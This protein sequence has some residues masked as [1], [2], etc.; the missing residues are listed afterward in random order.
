MISSSEAG[1]L[2]P[3]TAIY[4]LPLTTLSRA[5]ELSAKCPIGFRGFAAATRGNTMLVQPPSLPVTIHWFAK[6]R[7]PA[8]N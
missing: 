6:M 3:H 4:S 5:N 8:R 1:K 2:D 7:M